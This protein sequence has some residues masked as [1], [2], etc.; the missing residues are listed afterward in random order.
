MSKI[1]NS[2]D[3]QQNLLQIQDIFFKQGTKQDALNHLLQNNITF[4]DL[5]VTL[6]CDDDEKKI[7]L[8]VSLLELLAKFEGFN[9]DLINL[10]LKQSQIKKSNLFSIVTDGGKKYFLK[11]IKTHSNKFINQPFINEFF[12]I[13]FMDKSSGVYTQTL[14]LIIYLMKNDLI[15]AER[16]GNLI[17]DLVEYFDALMIKSHSIF[18]VRKF[19]IYLCFIDHIY[20]NELLN[21][22]NNTTWIKLKDGI[23]NICKDFYTYDLLTQLAILETMESNI[24]D[25]KILLLLNP[26]KNFFNENIMSLD[27]QTMRKLLLSFSK[28]YARYLI[29]DNEIKLLKNTLAISFQ[30]YNDDKHIQFMCYLL[31]N[32]FN[33]THIYGFIMNKTNNNTFDFLNNTIEVMSSI[34]IINDPN[35]KCQIYEALEKVFDFGDGESDKEEPDKKKPDKIPYLGKQNISEH[36]QFIILL[37]TE[38]I[39]KT[40]LDDLVKCKTDDE[41]KGKFM[42]YLYNDFKKNDL[43]DYEL[44]YLRLIYYIVSDD[45]NT[46]ILLS[47]FDFVLYL[48]K[49]RSEKPHEVCEMKFKVIKR[50]NEKKNIISQ[51]SNA[52]SQQFIDYIKK[53]PY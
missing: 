21:K 53:G 14:Q 15:T 20:K 4:E 16:L 46:K 49:R 36:K 25:T 10:I 13:Y 42:E 9:D 18:L 8:L 40:S 41:I 1:V 38:I 26:N 51:M 12:K 39:K 6:V 5:L 29:T 52:F 45:D 31:N 2:S 30:Y 22:E 24:N 35:I 7:D 11:I 23:Q 34:F 37:L 44:C 28:F 19:E 3:I 47:N 27:A 32:I 43:P 48:L 33:N 50:I 17:Q